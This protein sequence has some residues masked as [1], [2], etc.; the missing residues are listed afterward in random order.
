MRFGGGTQG[1]LWA[2]FFASLTVVGTWGDQPPSG[3][4]GVRTDNCFRGTAIANLQW[5]R[6][7]NFMAALL[8]SGL[9]HLT[10]TSATTFQTFPHKRSAAYATPLK[11]PSRGISHSGLFV[12]GCCVVLY[13]GSWTSVGSLSGGSVTPHP[14][15]LVSYPWA[16][17][18]PPYRA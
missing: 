18:G 4:V 10:Q 1:P 6:S 13:E 11:R 8:T 16:Q 2:V 15:A 3:V 14:V 5:G 17:R 12:R 7:P 9:Q